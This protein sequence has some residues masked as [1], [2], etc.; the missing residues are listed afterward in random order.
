MNLTIFKGIFRENAK[1]NS[2]AKIIEKFILILDDEIQAMND[3][4]GLKYSSKS[5]KLVYQTKF[6]NFGLQ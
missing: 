4:V 6:N 1:N 3:H 2:A 5:S